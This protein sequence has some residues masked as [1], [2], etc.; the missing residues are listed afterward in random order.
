ML[1]RETSV[2]QLKKL[3]AETKGKDIGD[4]TS[5]DRL[6]HN[7]PNLQYIGNP[8]DT[9]IESWEEFSKK[10]SKLQTIAFKSKLANK[11]IKEN[12]KDIMKDDVL[13]FDDF[14]NKKVNIIKEEFIDTDEL[15]SIDKLKNFYGFN[16]LDN[17]TDLDDLD[18]DTDLDD[19]DDED[20]IDNEID[21][22]IN[23]FIKKYDESWGK[24][25]VAGSLMTAATIGGINN[26]DA[27]TRNKPQNSIQQPS[28]IVQMQKV[29]SDSTNYIVYGKGASSD[30]VTARKI[31]ISNA[32]IKLSKEI[33]D[34]KNITSEV[35]KEKCTKSDNG[36]YKC[37]VVLSVE[38][39]VK[40]VKKFE[41]FTVKNVSTEEKQPEYTM[42]GKEKEPKSDPN[43]GIGAV[44]AQEIKKITDFNLIDPPTPKERTI[45]GNAGV[46]IDNDTVKGFVNR[47]DGKDVYVESVDNPMVIK[48]FN[49]KDVVKT[50]K[51]K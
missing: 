21:E 48:K 1:P 11:H 39:N 24:N 14:E 31:A 20:E 49:I 19:L 18:D 30:L 43:F 28:E 10:D 33:G 47:I 45:G 8:V 34:N 50:K 27:N 32:K 42:L 4:L 2:R 38:K 25:I 15:D 17:D 7:I 6:N 5:G 40:D 9:G 23:T 37:H 16:D 26:A 35:T 12:N 29:K 36:E 46:F 22:K 51:V 44:K 41:S 13:N 3:R